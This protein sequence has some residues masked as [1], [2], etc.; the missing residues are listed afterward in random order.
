[1]VKIPKDRELFR[2]TK[3]ASIYDG[4]FIN[5]DLSIYD[6]KDVNIKYCVFINCKFPK[7]SNWLQ[8]ICGK[9][10]EGCR[11]FNCDLS[12]QSFKDM[13]ISFCKFLGETKLPIDKNFFINLRN[14]LIKGV[15]FPA[16]DF[17]NCLFTGVSISRANFH[18]KSLLPTDRNIFAKM[19]SYIHIAIPDNII[20]YIHLFDVD[21]DKINFS[22]QR[23]M[24]STEQKIIIDHKLLN[25]RGV[26]KNLREE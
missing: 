16:Q 11:F 7:D 26:N 8:S 17:S 4:T 20:K 24:L 22:K 10:I 21:Y 5:Q 25:S 13:D 18:R 12:N 2:K 9:T 23:T 1:M 6:F 14:K 15:T 19:S 3:G